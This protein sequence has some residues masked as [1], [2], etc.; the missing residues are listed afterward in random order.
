MAVRRNRE[1]R[2]VTTTGYLTAFKGR[3]R[4]LKPDRVRRSRSGFRPTTPEGKTAFWSA[5]QHQ[6]QGA[7]ET[8][9]RFNIDDLAAT[10]RVLRQ[11]NSETD[12]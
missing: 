3:F 5:L 2:P 8:S 6:I 7:N 9:K 4:T 10:A 11:L 1:S 12:R